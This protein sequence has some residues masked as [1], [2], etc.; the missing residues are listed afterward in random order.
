MKPIFAVFWNICLLRQGPEFVPTHPLFVGGVLIADL[1]LSFF[2]GFQYGNPTT[3][4]QAA[5]A[6][7]VTMATLAAAVWL[8]LNAR[9]VIARY[10]ATIA[11]IFGCDLL[12]TL[13]FAILIP[14]SGGAASQV[15]MGMTALLGIWSIAVNGFILH[16]AMNVTLFV[17]IFVAFCVA[18]LA[19][20]LSS[21][22]AGR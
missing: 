20:V 1:L 14:L 17:G 11:A 9:G 3:P 4:L 22:A 5:T 18:L 10:P 15:I 16:R 2:F 12:F 8:A 13:S 7:F 19:F 6:T 21:A